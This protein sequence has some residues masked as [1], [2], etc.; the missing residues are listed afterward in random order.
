MVAGLDLRLRQAIKF[1]LLMNSKPQRR[2]GSKSLRTC[3]LLINP[4]LPR[5]WAASQGQRDPGVARLLPTAMVGAG[6]FRVGEVA[7]GNYLVLTEHQP[8]VAR[9]ADTRQR[10][11]AFYVGHGR[12]A[13]RYPA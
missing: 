6:T 2:W 8:A 7:D 11:L 4:S 1:E 9:K 13:T 3:S 10:L 12:T 5:T